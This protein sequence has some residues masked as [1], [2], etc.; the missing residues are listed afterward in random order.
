MC[1]CNVRLWWDVGFFS[2]LMQ[3]ALDR[4]VLCNGLVFGGVLIPCFVCTGD[5]GEVGGLIVHAS[6]LS[7]PSR[8]P[9]FFQSA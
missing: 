5:S 1:M 2:V 9:G 6:A 7:A 4:C 8:P 3:Q